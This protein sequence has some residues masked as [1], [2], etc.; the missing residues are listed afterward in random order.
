MTAVLTENRSLVLFNQYVMLITRRCVAVGVCER[1][2]PIV[3]TNWWHDIAFLLTI[4]TQTKQTNLRPFL[5]S[6]PFK[7]HR[8]SSIISTPMSLFQ[9]FS[10]CVPWPT[11]VPQKY[12]AV[13]T[14][15]FG[16]KKLHCRMSC[17]FSDI[18]R[19][20]AESCGE[21]Q[22]D[23]FCFFVFWRSPVFGRKNRFNLI[24]D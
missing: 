20:L 14:E 4:R 7:H 21:W 24:Q 23:L 12:F 3:G 16:L 11:S 18:V 8:L 17:L 9:W 13:A 22:V 6:G 10:T 15:Q 5:E 19:K 1:V 2:F